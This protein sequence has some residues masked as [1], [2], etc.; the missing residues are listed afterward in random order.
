MDDTMRRK[1]RQLSARAANEIL[2]QGSIC[3]L[4]MAAQGEPYLVTLNYGY[5]DSALYFH[6]AK[7]GRK[8]EILEQNNRVCFTVVE[9]GAVLPA[10]KACDFTMKYRSVV[11][12]G[13]ARVIDGYREKCEALGIIMAQ[14][15]PGD[16]FEFPEATLAATTVFVVDISSMAAKSNH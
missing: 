4:A 16:S 10:D 15:A 3:Q 14:Y 7:A 1:D 13:T 2:A 11:G 6:C 5:R 8:L 12:Y 9:H